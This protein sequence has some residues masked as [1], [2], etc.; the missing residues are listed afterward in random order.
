MLIVERT[1]NVLIIFLPSNKF[2][3]WKIITAV[4]LPETVHDFIIFGTNFINSRKLKT[5][6]KVYNNDNFLTKEAG[7][8]F[9]A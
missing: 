2:I 6:F 5:Y 3:E 7:S 8:T 4:K 1:E 9:G